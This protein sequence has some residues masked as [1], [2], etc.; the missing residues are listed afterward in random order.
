MITNAVSGTRVDEVAEGIHRISTPVSIISGGFSFNQYLV[1][2]DQP[3]LFHTGPRRLFS[4]VSEAVAAI[5]PLERLRYVGLS[6]FEAD[7]CGA[8]NEFLAAARDAEPICSQVAAMVS[9]DD[10]ATRKGRPLADG[11]T[12]ELGRHR[13]RWIDTPHV[14][15][16]WDCGYLFDETT[17]P[18]CAATSS[19]RAARNTRPSPNPTS[20]G[21]AR[22][23]ARAWTTTR[24]AQARGGASSDWPRSHPRRSPACT[25]LPG[26]ETGGSCSVPLR[27]CSPASEPH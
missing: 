18:C 16:G 9:V 2:D 5:M 13:L 11:E 12:L 15:H 14:P 4:L 19:R 27:I 22:R 1:V 10:M 3:L 26:A 20:W 23:C 7:E 21:R 6:H 25:A 8:L 24:M 17:A